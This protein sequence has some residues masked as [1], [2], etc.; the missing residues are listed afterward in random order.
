MQTHHLRSSGDSWWVGAALGPPDPP[1][2]E[3]LH[4]PGLLES[5]LTL[6]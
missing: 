5:A 2:E 3:N 4:V 6:N 1:Y